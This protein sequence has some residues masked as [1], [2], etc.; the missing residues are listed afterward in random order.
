MDKW[1][2]AAH[3]FAQRGYDER[4]KIVQEIAA[5]CESPIERLMAVALAELVVSFRAKVLA[6]VKPIDLGRHYFA[7]GSVDQILI[8][9]QQ[10]IGP[11]RVDF[12]MRVYNDGTGVK[13]WY[14]IECDGHDF[15]ERTKEQAAA[16][17]AR[18]RALTRAGYKVI[19][20][21]GSELHNR[22]DACLSD[23]GD[24]IIAALI[25]GE[26]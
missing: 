17:R 14:V 19:R 21:T 3:E 16:D 20:F 10:Q 7:G 25:G 13:H 23:L 5:Y 11:Y 1:E 22:L 12:A 24:I 6:P 4:A 26:G 9:P 8:W 2:E 15:H 18:D